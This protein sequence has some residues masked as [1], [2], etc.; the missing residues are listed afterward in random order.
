MRAEILCTGD[1]IRSGAVID[2][3]SAF[4]AR[5]LEDIGIE[6]N[7]HTCVGDDVGDTAAALR[8]MAARAQ[9]V[10]V[11]GGLGPTIDDLTRR[12]AIDALGGETEERKEITEAIEARYRALGRKPPDGYRDHAVVPRGARPLANG[13]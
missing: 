11:T 3:N 2:T 7:R 4:I 5:H 10:V 9:A 13:S 1:E 12:A 8:E 6:I